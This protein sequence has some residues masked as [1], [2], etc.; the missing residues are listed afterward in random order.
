MPPMSKQASV[1]SEGPPALSARDFERFRRLA[2]E[3]VGLNLTEAKHQL[4]AARL[5]KKLRELRL[6]SFSEYYDRVVADRTGESLIGLIDALSTNHTSF[7]REASHF[8]FLRRALPPLRS[9]PVIHVWSAPCSSGEEPYS[10]AITLLEELG[11][12]PCP[13]VK[14]RAVDVS[15]RAIASAK[16]GVYAAERLGA[17]PFPLIKK[18]FQPAGSG[19][20]QVK[21]EVRRLI[22]FARVNLIE[23]L[24]E[25][26]LY[27]VI[28][29]RNMMIYF[30]KP[31]QERLVSQLE[32]FMEP[33]GYLFIGHS[34]SLMGIH[35]ALE[36][37]QP[38]IYRKPGGL[39][40]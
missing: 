23:P 25:T 15:T 14:I 40:R 17:L 8:L 2:Y 1:L 33:G 39:A 22:E 11:L 38:S 37:V 34:E 10:I 28:F 29:C 4:M 20:F 30:D 9:R 27:P 6:A 3:K 21:P 32:R 26:R 31:T 18:Y 35:H 36:Y 5:G 24:A 12:P 7:L 13:D 19:V 16:K